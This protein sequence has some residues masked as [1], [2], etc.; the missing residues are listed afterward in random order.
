MHDT[1]Y[2]QNYHK[3]Q[4]KDDGKCKDL[5]KKQ[6]PSIMVLRY[7]LFICW[8]LT[9][10]KEIDFGMYWIMSSLIFSMASLLPLWVRIG[11]IAMFPAFAGCKQWLFLALIVEISSDVASR[12]TPSVFSGIRI[13]ILIYHKLQLYDELALRNPK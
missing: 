4:D 6:T 7:N 3:Y 8:W 11:V 5:H 13:L 12:P 2:N 1:W 10:E 9:L